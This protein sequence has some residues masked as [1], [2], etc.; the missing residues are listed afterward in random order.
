VTTRASQ[1]LTGRG[2]LLFKTLID[3]TGMSSSSS[4]NSWNRSAGLEKCETGTK[5]DFRQMNWSFQ[6][7]ITKDDC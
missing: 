5:N 4:T 2:G 3:L 7:I 6:K 1:A